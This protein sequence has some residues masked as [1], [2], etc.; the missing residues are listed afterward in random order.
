MRFALR[1]ADLVRGF[2]TV[3]R[4]SC[5]YLERLLD[6]V[7]AFLQA[8]VSYVT[9]ETLKALVLQAIAGQFVRRVHL[10]LQ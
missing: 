6:S 4:A 1:I 5:R 8:S 3:R 9:Q 2:V 7:L 10:R